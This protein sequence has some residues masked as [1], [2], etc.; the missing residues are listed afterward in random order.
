VTR[1]WHYTDARN[2]PSIQERGLVPHPLRTDVVKAAMGD[3]LITDVAGATGVFVWTRRQ[4]A[5]S[6][7]GLVALKSM[8]TLTAQ[9]ALLEVEWP[10]AD[11]VDTDRPLTH[12]GYLDGICIHRDEP[13]V[14][15]A[16]T[17]TPDRIRVVDVVPGAAAVGYVLG[18]S[19]V[20]A[21]WQAERMARGLPPGL[22][23]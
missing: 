18:A 17:I 3:P 22:A 13:F 15:V 7:F 11:T 20:L 6:H 19:G 4:T 1:G 10:D 14:I 9:V 8:R 16:Q 23:R 5:L 12:D 2:L 21:D